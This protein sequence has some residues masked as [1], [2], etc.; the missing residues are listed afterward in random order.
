MLIT[1]IFTN[2][3]ADFADF[4]DYCALKAEMVFEPFFIKLLINQFVIQ[5][6]KW[7]KYSG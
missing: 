3:N 5:K 4:A 2:T 7:F 6:F 1:T